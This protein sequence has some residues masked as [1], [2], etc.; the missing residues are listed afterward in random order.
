MG[1]FF[2]QTEGN[3]SRVYVK[4]IVKGGSADRFVWCLLPIIRVYVAHLLVEIPTT[5][6]SLRVK[7][8]NQEKIWQAVEQVEEC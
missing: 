3:R 8:T 2:Q 5:A 6:R 1:L 4:T 7:F